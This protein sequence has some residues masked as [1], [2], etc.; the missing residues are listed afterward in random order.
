MRK[1]T[2]GRRVRRSKHGICVGVYLTAM[3]SIRS[4]T[5]RLGMAR[6]APEIAPS[7]KSGVA[8]LRV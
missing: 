5:G 7:S 8:W 2:S 4:K 3:D 1:D 6:L